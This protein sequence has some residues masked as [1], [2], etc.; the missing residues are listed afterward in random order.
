MK[1]LVDKMP[2]SAQECLF[3]DAYAG[4][5]ECRLPGAE[6]TVYLLYWIEKCPYL[7]AKEDEN[8]DA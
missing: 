1:I 3:C 7:V 6:D 5:P 8:E 4:S 2:K